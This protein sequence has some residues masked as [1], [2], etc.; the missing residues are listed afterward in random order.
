MY[1]YLFFLMLGV[2]AALLAVNFTKS[3]TDKAQVV[4][5]YSSKRTPAKTASESA[6]PKV[7]KLISREEKKREMKK[8]K[9]VED[10]KDA[11][12][13]NQ[14]F[15]LANQYSF[16]FEYHDLHYEEFEAVVEILQKKS[17]EPY[18]CL[19]SGINNYGALEKALSSNISQGV[20]ERVLDMINKQNS[21][22][23]ICRTVNHKIEI[24]DDVKAMVNEIHVYNSELNFIAD[25]GIDPFTMEEDPF[26]EADPFAEDGE[27][28]LASLDVPVDAPIDEEE[29]HSELKEEL[30]R[31]SIQ[32]ELKSFM[33]ELPEEQ[34]QFLESYLEVLS[35]HVE[36]S[37]E[38]RLRTMYELFD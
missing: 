16:L 8:N 5:E 21:F 3:E 28:T 11:L 12:F 14:R 18:G 9:R 33:K 10:I 29:I 19:G 1:K 32:K 38:L 20:S 24:I 4:K 15:Q 22:E 30:R 35:K 13:R 26:A 27:D 36:L 17:L 31:M 34:I 6:L 37:D 7:I 2:N 25:F 23:S